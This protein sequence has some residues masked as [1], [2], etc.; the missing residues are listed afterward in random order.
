M[1]TLLAPNGNTSNLN[2]KQYKLVRTSAF[3]KWFGD[4]EILA[5]A[6]TLLNDIKGVYKLVALNNIEMFLFEISQQANSSKS[7]YDGAIKTVGKRIVELSLK[8]FPNSKVGDDFIPVVSKVVDENEEP[9]IVWHGGSV[10]NTFNKNKI[11]LNDDGWYGYGFYFTEDKSFASEWGELKPYFILINN[12]FNIVQ[13]GISIINPFYNNSKNETDNK[14]KEG[15]NGSIAKLSKPN[16][17]VVYYEFSKNIKLADGSN[18]TF[19]IN[20][21]DIRYEKGGLIAPNGKPSKLNPEQYKLVRTPAFK[22]W[23]GD[24]EKDPEN[25]SKIIDEN[26]EP[27]ICFHGTP[28]ARFSV[29]DKNKFH[30]RSK[31]PNSKGFFFT[32]SKEYAEAYSE[33]RN[34]EWREK[35]KEVLGYYPTTIE[36]RPYAK[37]IPCFLKIIN[38]KYAENSLLDTIKNIKYNDGL[39]VNYYNDKN[40]VFEIMVFN[41]NQIK[42]A[43]GSNTTFDANN[44]DIRYENGG[45]LNNKSTSVIVYHGSTRQFDKFDNSKLGEATKSKSAKFGFWFT[46][47]IKTAKS[48]PRAEN[49]NKVQYFIDNND[50]KSAEKLEN[51]IDKNKDIKYLKKVRLTYKNPLIIDAEENIYNDFSNEIE[52]A[53]KIAI[54]NKNDVLIVKRLSDNADYSEYT[55]ANHYLVLDNSIIEIISENKFNNGGS[56]LLAPNG[57]ASKLNPEQYK[58]VRTPAFKKWFGDWEN[59]PENSS[60]VIDKETKEPMICF[61]GTENK[62]NVFKISEYGQLGKGIYF[63]NYYN[64]AKQYSELNNSKKAK[65]ISV[66]LNIK[67]PKYTTNYELKN[68]ELFSG[69][70]NEVYERLIDLKYDGLIFEFEK[71]SLKKD[72][73]IYLKT[74]QMELNAFKSEQIKLADGSNTTFNK[75]N[76]DIRFNIGGDVSDASF[77]NIKKD[78]INY[79]DVLK[80]IWSN[81]NINF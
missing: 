20:N 11:G 58:L 2:E 52:D 4:W 64:E 79:L 49:W 66:F 40:K 62:F 38:P 19:D 6:K 55:P 76:D 12:P 78:K 29:F 21:N 26:G 80:D 57:K 77:N 23:F 71:I 69:Q 63:S 28:D 44:N 65:V 25:S 33:S 3:K 9:L 73:Y 72:K 68:S 70:S 10:E 22:K 32:P 45:A 54:E 15:Y 59:E 39:I 42:L 48:Y 1:K 7:E 5:E 13:K 36:A 47:D 60:K 56:V 53:I 35:A 30:T 41:P 16:E 31:S 51:D 46:D 34:N 18:T 50:I 8:L 37:E 43:D 67:N 27:M 24:W 14:I 17:Y 74:G 75:N 81:F 61:H